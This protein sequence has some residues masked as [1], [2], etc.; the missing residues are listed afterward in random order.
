M[1]GRINNGKNSN[2]NKKIFE[3]NKRTIAHKKNKNKGEENEKKK[4]IRQNKMDQFT[5]YIKLLFKINDIDKIILLIL[6]TFYFYY[7]LFSFKK[8]KSSN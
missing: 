2:S 3:Q 4:K 5:R 1:N 6:I 8:K 7:Y